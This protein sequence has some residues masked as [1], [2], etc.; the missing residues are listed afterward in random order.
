M[1][2]GLIEETGLV[3]AIKPLGGGK[4]LSIAARVVMDGLKIDDSIALD[5]VCQTVVRVNETSFDVEAV[6]E[7]LA[8]T[9]I[10]SLSVGST[11]NLERAARLGG[12]MGG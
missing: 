8:K 7:T 5:G 6:E 10:N 2:T 3:K 11:I 9:T 1:F 12:R 4:R